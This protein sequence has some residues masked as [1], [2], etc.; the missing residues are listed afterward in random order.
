V[1]PS[2]TTLI[3]L[4]SYPQFLIAKFPYTRQPEQGYSIAIRVHLNFPFLTVTALA[5]HILPYHLA[6]PDKVRRCC[7]MIGQEADLIRK[8]QQWDDAATRVQAGEFQL[9]PC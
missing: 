4:K 3:M 6:T 8:R 5:E 2:L 1:V 7:R 9:K